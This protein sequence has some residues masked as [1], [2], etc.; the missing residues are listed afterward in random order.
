MFAVSDLSCNS[1]LYLLLDTSNDRLID[2]APFLG[3]LL[4]C[5][6]FWQ[7]GIVNTPCFCNEPLPVMVYHSTVYENQYKTYY[8]AKCN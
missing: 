1:G 7:Y 3:D 6:L 8:E 4:V 5:L 2:W